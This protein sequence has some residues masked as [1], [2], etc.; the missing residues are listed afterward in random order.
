MT[1]TTWLLVAGLGGAASPPARTIVVALG[2]DD[3]AI[4]RVKRRETIEAEDRRTIVS[5]VEAVT[6]LTGVESPAAS[7]RGRLIALLGEARER[8]A[9][10][11]T[12]RAVALYREIIA[13]YDQALF[14]SAP[15]RVATA[16]AIQ[17]LAATLHA[18]GSVEEAATWARE[19]MRRFP[20]HPPDA[21]RH[22]PRVIALFDAANDALLAD[23][24][25]KLDVVSTKGGEVFVD[26][27]SLGRSRG[28]V[29]RT[30]PA[31]RYRAWLVTDDGI[32]L[33]HPVDLKAGAEIEIT[34]DAELDHCLKLAPVLTLTCEQTWERDL[35]SLMRAVGATRGVGVPPP[36]FAPIASSVFTAGALVLSAADS[37]PAVGEAALGAPLPTFSPLYLIPL[38]GGQLA[39]ER[40][41][42]GV[43]YL[44]VDI[45]LVVWSIIASVGYDDV[46][47]GGNVEAEPGAR[48]HRNIAVGV[49]ASFAAAT[50]VEAVIYGL[51]AGE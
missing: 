47:R 33:P 30:L 10:F 21:M 3:T 24:T 39:Q 7:D 36:E 35:Q 46:V 38:G 1:W 31:G 14:P 13:A 9:E 5:H 45:G 23:P 40:Y 11:E 48:L 42:F 12:E 20:D 43:T 16:Q 29:M 50:V 18:S 32:S 8:E 49:T 19:A 2:E 22:P 28:R 6:R 17:E 4:D 27:R 25:G 34:I 26:G 44:A 51:V 15:Q 41:A 37:P